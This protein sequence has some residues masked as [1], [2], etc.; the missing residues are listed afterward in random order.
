LRR[1]DFPCRVLDHRAIGP[2]W[3]AISPVRSMQIAEY[4]GFT[5]CGGSKSPERMAIPAV[6]QP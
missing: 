2:L 1:Y 3:R 5:L 6:D 4:R